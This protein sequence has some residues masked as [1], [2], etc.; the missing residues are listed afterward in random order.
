M[1]VTEHT[2]TSKRTGLFWFKTLEGFT[3]WLVAFTTLYFLL[4]GME[5]KGLVHARQ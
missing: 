4:L 3:Q 5:H 1:A 2:G